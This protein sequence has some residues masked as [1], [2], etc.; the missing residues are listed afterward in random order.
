MTTA[1]W[2][3]GLCLLAA[4]GAALAADPLPLDNKRDVLTY[5]GYTFRKVYDQQSQQWTFLATK[6]GKVAH[7]FLSPRPGSILGDK[8][9]AHT[10]SMG[11]VKAIK[12]R[13]S[14]VVLMIWTG[15]KNC[16]NVYWIVNVVP[17]FRV[18]LDTSTYSFDELILARDIDGDGDI[19]LS[20]GTTTFDY[21]GVAFF[22]SPERKHGSNMTRR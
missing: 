7:V 19:E 3:A 6:D 9:S 10:L 2:I 14:Q 13:Q 11:V 12:G 17:A 21:F 4:Q 22:D 5:G 20:F 8:E 15:G 1:S 16:C 18:I